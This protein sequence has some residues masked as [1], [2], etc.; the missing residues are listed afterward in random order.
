MTLWVLTSRVTSSPGRR[1]GM[2]RRTMLAFAVTVALHATAAC[3]MQNIDT[4][5][6][7]GSVV[8]S[9]S[10]ASFACGHDSCVL[11]SRAC[12]LRA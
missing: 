7:L 6:A 12:R 2:H 1:G 5:G 10:R 11:A 3:A 9:P 4:A 8:A